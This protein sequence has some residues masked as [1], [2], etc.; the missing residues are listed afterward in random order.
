MGPERCCLL[1]LVRM[2][3]R[4]RAC[5]GEMDLFKAVREIVLRAVITHLLGDGLLQLYPD[6]IADFMQYQVL[7]IP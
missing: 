3:H 4:A 5:A 6:L 7:S 2:M 1:K